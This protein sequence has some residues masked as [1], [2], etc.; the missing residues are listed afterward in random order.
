MNRTCQC[1]HRRR[2]SACPVACVILAALLALLP[3]AGCEKKVAD[4]PPQPQT[5]TAKSEATPTPATV[6]P[7]PQPGKDAKKTSRVADEKDLP[8]PQQIFDRHIE[9]TGGREAYEKLRNVLTQGTIRSTRSGQETGFTEYRAASNKY[10]QIIESD[11]RGARRTG[12]DGE[13]VWLLTEEGVP[14]I[15]EPSP[16]RGPAPS[17]SV[18]LRWKS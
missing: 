9:M 12:C 13:T 8:S 15:S 4:T 1:F 3:A 18:Y 11:E 17:A 14:F 6:P 16:V 7:D 5:I 2:E 10:L